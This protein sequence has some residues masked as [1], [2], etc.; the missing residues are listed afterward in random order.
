M[1]HL[2]G[3]VGP[4]LHS[5]WPRP[6]GVALMIAGLAH[7]A[8][9]TVPC[10]GSGGGP[11]GLIAAVDTA[12]STPGPNTINLTPGCV[13]TLTTTHE[14]SGGISQNGLAPITGTLTI[15]GYGATVARSPVGTPFFRIFS[16]LAGGNLTLN[17][18]TVK[19]GFAD[20][21]GDAQSPCQDLNNQF[22]VVGFGGGVCVDGGGILTLNHSTV[23]E[24]SAGGVEG[25][26][27][28]GG[29]YN[30]GS[31]TLNNSV[32]SKNSASVNEGRA[33]GGGIYNQGQ[34]TLH[35]S[36]VSRNSVSA[37]GIDVGL[38]AGGGIYSV[39]TS[40]H[41][42]S[43]IMHHSLVSDNTANVYF[44]GTGTGGG[45]VVAPYSSAVLD[46]SAIRNN[47]VTVTGSGETL[48]A[49][50]GID[51]QAL[52]VTVSGCIAYGTATLDHVVVF[53]NN[54]TA[55]VDPGASNDA[56]ATARGGGLGISGKATL[57]HTFV[58]SN[59]ARASDGVARGGGIDNGD[60]GTAILKYS[61]VVNN[62]AAGNTLA[63]SLGGGIYNANPA[64]G[65]VTLT[66]TQ[67]KGNHPDQCDP[68]GSV[69]GCSN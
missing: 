38:S 36:T 25:G 49:G 59:T 14:G 66:V 40:L 29:I 31:V 35:C 48:A 22:S 20:F 27:G 46:H 56:T 61:K 24:N 16:V 18:V 65:S 57:L 11:S 60:T 42:G 19:G 45:I 41:R 43:L 28:G 2:L 6:I 39:G 21:I 33:N 30:L 58:H 62:T 34:L 47:I 63:D 68:T 7:A 52:C 50:A 37:G 54:A 5:N 10:S 13:Y 55:S 69:P 53:G 23:T 1:S 44:E 12:N 15:N 9:Q 32:V 51:V 26:A 67:V 8:T 3:R 64:S 4:F 17:T